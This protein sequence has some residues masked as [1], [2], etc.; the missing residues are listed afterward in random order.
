MTTEYSCGQAE[1]PAT[2]EDSA[3]QTPVIEGNFGLDAGQL[4]HPIAMPP[5]IA[6]SVR[7]A[8]GCFRTS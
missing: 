5:G 8:E 4:G 2:T 6:E 7:I 3:S 1:T